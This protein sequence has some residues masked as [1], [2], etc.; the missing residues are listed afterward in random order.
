MGSGVFNVAVSG[1]NAAQLGIQTTSHNIANASTTGYNRQR[2]EQAT[3]T[4]LFTGAG[5]IGQGT[6]VETVSRVYSQF[7]TEQVL[8][9]QSNV[10]EANAYLAQIEQIDNLLADPNAGLS[11]AMAVVFLEGFPGA[12][13]QAGGAPMRR[14]WC[15]AA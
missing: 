4:P 1:L 10:E 2:I 13:G 6:N 14:I 8:A 7:L 11:P 15:I 9:A 12:A 3:N 5:F